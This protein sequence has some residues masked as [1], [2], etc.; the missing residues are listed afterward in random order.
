MN[1]EN[2]SNSGNNNL[3]GNNTEGG[4]PNPKGG[5]PEPKWRPYFYKYYRTDADELRTSDTSPD[6]VLETY[7]PTGD[8]PPQND[9]QLGVLIDYRYHF[10]VQHLGYNHWYVNR[11]F[12]GGNIIDNIAKERLFAHIFD[13]RAV[14]SNAYNQLN[15]ANGTPNWNDVR[16]TSQIIA[17]LNNSNN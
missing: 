10:Y 17:S 3:E 11:I 14:L 2:A 16:I 5:S 1:N 7:N 8:V 9:K 15:L 13:Q 6:L 12:P 4:N